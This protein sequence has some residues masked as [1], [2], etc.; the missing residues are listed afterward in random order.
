MLPWRISPLYGVAGNGGP[1]LSLRERLVRIE[2]M[3]SID[4]LETHM[5]PAMI[6]GRKS[7]PVY[8]GNFVLLFVLIIMGDF[9]NARLNAC[10]TWLESGSDFCCHVVGS[11]S[12]LDMNLSELPY[13]SYALAGRVYRP[14][15]VENRVPRY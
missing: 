8:T 10:L 2:M 5:R 7:L 11:Y 3:R 6:A 1:G 12:R 14:D 9:I 4:Q 13:M 15:V